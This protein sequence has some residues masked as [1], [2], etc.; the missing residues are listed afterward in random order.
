MASPPAEFTDTRVV[1]PV[2]R[3]WTKTSSVPFVSPG[4]RL[5]AGDV[6]ATNRPVAEIDGLKLPKLLAS[7][8]AEFT[9]TSVRPPPGGGGP[10]GRIPRKP[11]NAPRGVKS[12]SA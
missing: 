1:T 8:P 3:S 5:L 11:R 2:F 9:D 7:S 6:K 4:T 12:L 10:R